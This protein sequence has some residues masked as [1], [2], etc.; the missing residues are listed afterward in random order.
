MKR[1]R[2]H[3][4]KLERVH[5]GKS[6]VEMK[7]WGRFFTPAGFVYCVVRYVFFPA[8]AF[9]VTNSKTMRGWKEC[10]RDRFKWR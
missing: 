4:R 9:L 8:S 2:V 7:W 1:E 5:E 6:C 3:L 10:K